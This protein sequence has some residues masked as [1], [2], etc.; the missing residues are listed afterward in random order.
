M[1]VQEAELERQS[2]GRHVSSL[3]QVVES[4]SQDLALARVEL[5]HA[6]IRAAAKSG[7]AVDDPTARLTQLKA[8]DKEIQVG[9]G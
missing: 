6:R 2:L 8:K 9:S 7:V 1:R 3:Q 5:D 4:L